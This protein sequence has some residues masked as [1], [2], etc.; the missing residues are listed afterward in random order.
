MRLWL[1]LLPSPPPLLLLLLLLLLLCLPFC[2]RQRIVDVQNIDFDITSIE[3]NCWSRGLCDLHEST[4]VDV[5][6]RQQRLPG[7]A[8][9]MRFAPSEGLM[10][11]KH[12]SVLQPR[13]DGV[14]DMAKNRV[15]VCEPSSYKSGRTV[16]VVNRVVTIVGGQ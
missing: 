4:S 6:S 15:T 11:V 12:C 10:S 13:S 16:T 1:S 5:R 14:P 3:Q 8:S 7:I 2:Q 9:L